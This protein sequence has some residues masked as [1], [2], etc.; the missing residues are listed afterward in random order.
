ML[1]ILGILFCVSFIYYLSFAALLLIKNV[2]YNVL[3]QLC[4]VVGY[5]VALFVYI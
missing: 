5:L 4:S 3:Q 1:W 2:C